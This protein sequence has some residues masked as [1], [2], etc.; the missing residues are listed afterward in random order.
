MQKTFVKTGMLCLLVLINIQFGFAG[1]YDNILSGKAY[2][3][4]THQPLVGATVYIPELKIGTTSN[5]GGNYI[6]KNLPAGS[7]LVQ[8]QYVGYTTLSE[9]ITVK[10]ATHHDFSLSASVIEQNEVVVTG[11]SMATEA[12]RSPMPIQSISSLQL[13]RQSYTNIINAIAKEPGVNEIT[14]GPAISKPVIRGLGYNRVVVVNDG[15]RQEGQQWGD[16]HGIEV[17]DYNVNKVEILKGLL[18]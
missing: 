13:K 16:E 1:Y 9:T 14:T 17:D 18:R 5:A 6:L 2:D 3:A 10:G 8:V 11:M 4:A 15:I 12:K 7:Y